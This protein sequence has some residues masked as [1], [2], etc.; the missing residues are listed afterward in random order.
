MDKKA[1][2]FS[3]GVPIGP[4]DLGGP[5]PARHI[6]GDYEVLQEV[7]RGGMGVVYR[8]LDLNLGRVVALKML[9][10][11]LRSQPRTV[12]RFAR[13]ARAA[14]SLDHPNIVQVFSV[15]AEE[16]IPYMAMEYVD[17]EPLSRIVRR[18][19][20][21]PH[22][23]ALAIAE[24]VAAALA[25]AHE[26]HV[27]HRDIKPP[28]IL[29]DAQGKAYVTDFGIAKI[30]T[31]EDHLT[32]DGSRI[33]T[34]QYMSPELCQ[35]RELTASSD[36]YSLGVVVFMMLTARLPHEAANTLALIRK[37]VDEPP[38]RLRDWA[39]EI[40]EEVE[41]LVAY[42]LEKKP[43]D[44][45]ESA[46]AAQ[47]A[48]ARVRAGRPLDDREIKV[49]STLAS[50]RASV[51]T[52]V[53]EGASRTR[54]A[55]GAFP[56]WVAWAAMLAGALAVVTLALSWVF[57]STPGTEV[58][59][60]TARWLQSPRLATCVNEGRAVVLAQFHLPHFG[61]TA[62]A[63]PNGDSSL[64]VQVDGSKSSARDGQRAV[65]SLSPT[66]L[67]ASV[68]A[69]P[70]PPQAFATGLP[71]LDGAMSAA[72]SIEVPLIDTPGEQGVKVAHPTHPFRVAIKPDRKGQPQ[73]WAAD[74][75]DPSARTQITCLEG[76]IR[77]PCLVSPD[78]RWCAAVMR[79]ASLPT[80]VLADLSGVAE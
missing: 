20:P 15:G 26:A 32:V 70:L 35:N 39:P 9:R 71:A 2:A 37:I 56:T 79:E 67:E 64:R 80:V 78:G 42:L 74:C 19:G 75:H 16:Q 45:P 34:P 7:G 38:A 25:C 44:R 49:T 66:R 22:A 57:F 10:Q 12:S 24:Q 73:L 53:C 14:A 23:R 59:S 13:E 33:G 3:F 60:D 76:G 30:L 29:V 54:A 47:A 72:A 11:D 5:A 77:P 63:W 4:P 50:F 40:P 55:R 36:I 27:V 51:A 41:R 8:A 1:T 46:F 6:F 18:E 62:L 65:C 17:A 28:N 68:I 43:K 52:P 61:V 31:V 69:P 58:Q 21:L 48:I